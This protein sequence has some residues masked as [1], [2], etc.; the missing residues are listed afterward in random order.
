MYWAVGRGGAGELPFD[1]DHVDDFGLPA[2]PRG[3]YLS[4]SPV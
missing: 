1:G 2:A 3:E 4:Y